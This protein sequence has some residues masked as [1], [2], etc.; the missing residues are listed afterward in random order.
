MWLIDGGRVGVDGEGFGAVGK[1]EVGTGGHP[2]NP[3]NIKPEM[4]P[5]F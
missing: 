3:K 5:F 2:A 4:E 1:E